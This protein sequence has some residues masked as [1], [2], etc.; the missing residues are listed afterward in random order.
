V[1]T[2]PQ[3]VEYE[4][5]VLTWGHRPGVGSCGFLQPREPF[6][7]A[8]ILFFGT[9]CLTR[10]AGSFRGDDII[11]FQVQNRRCYRRFEASNFQNVA[12]FTQELRTKTDDLSR[13][14]YCRFSPYAQ[15]LLANPNVPEQTMK[16]TL[17]REFN[18]IVRKVRLARPDL[19]SPKVRLSEATQLLMELNPSHGEALMR[20]NSLVLRDVFPEYVN[21]DQTSLRPWPGDIVSVGSRDE[22]S[23]EPVRVLASV[24][25]LMPAERFGCVLLPD[26]TAA[27]FSYDYFPDES[28]LPD[29]ALSVSCR[30]IKT[31]TG[32]QAFDIWPLRGSVHDDD[33]IAHELPT[34]LKYWSPLDDIQ[35][36]PFHR[37]PQLAP[38]EGDQ[39]GSTQSPQAVQVTQPNPAVP[40]SEHHPQK[41]AATDEAKEDLCRGPFRY[42]W[43]SG[44]IILPKGKPPFY[45]L[46]KYQ[47]V[48]EYMFERTGV[49]RSDRR[50]KATYAEIALRYERGKLEEEN[51]DWPPEKA[52]AEVEKAANLAVILEKAKKIAQDFR[53]QFKRELRHKG[54]IDPGFIIEF[55][56]TIGGY[57]LFND[58][59][60]R[61]PVRGDSEAPQHERKSTRSDSGRVSNSPADQDDRAGDE[62]DDYD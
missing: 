18:D 35:D 17:A 21:T 45:L 43:Q 39:L 30:V 34:S 27:T 16:E 1:A 14:L 20:L 2:D 46:R 4:G 58:G 5:V 52:K 29:P 59:W 61:R 32:L 38:G 31:P 15:D 26:D 33:D 49:N 3:I 10:G 22:K 55:D 57:K 37:T 41:N 12:S 19:L 60:T 48:L 23:T 50:R 36:N 6:K 44:S 51:P 56:P 54:K 40:P 25:A 42:D 11:R 53:A 47:L 13:V 24:G 7:G 62:E 8:E 28:F 9:G